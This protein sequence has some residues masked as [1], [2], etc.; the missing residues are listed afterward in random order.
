MAKTSVINLSEKMTPEPNLIGYPILWLVLLA[1]LI[2]APTFKYGLTELDDTIFIRDFHDY[3]EHFSNLFSSFHRGLFDALK[4]PYYR[5]VF[6]DS[7]ILNYWLGNHGQNIFSYHFFNAWFHAAAVVFFYKLL[8]RL[9]FKTVMAFTL[10]AFFAVAPVLTQA[11]AWIPGRND[12]ILALFVLLFINYSIDF[13]RTNQKKFLIYAALNL[14][15]ALFTKETAV[16]APIVLLV[17]LSTFAG[18]RLVDRKTITT[19]LVCILCIVVWYLARNSATVQNGDLITGALPQLWHRLPL[20]LQYFGKIILPFNLSVFPMQDETTYIYGIVSV[21]ILF[22]LIYFSPAKNYKR[23]LGG[24]IIFIVFLVP[25]LIVPS[26]LNQ[27]TFE[28]RLYLP[29]IGFLLILPETIL[30]NGKYTEGQV[31]IYSIVV[32]CL[33]GG[34]TLS[35]QTNFS[36]PYAFWTQAVETSSK[37]AF[38]NMHLSEYEDNL[39]KKC[40]LI[41]HAFQLNPREK[42][43]NFFYAEMLINTGKRDSILSAEPYLQTEKGISNFNKCNFYLARIAIERGDYNSGIEDLTEFLKNEPPQSKEAA[44]ANNNLLLLFINTS[45]TNK[46]I[47]Q[48]RHM[49]DLGIPVPAEV[50]KQYHI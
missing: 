26:S 35:H 49:K 46:I 36:D 34:K 47:S 44:E 13:V 39:D 2:Y 3:N 21:V 7:M 11:V 50:Q 28:H 4:D 5:P 25:A 8:I 19:V 27:Q 22:I 16:F 14:L 12:T 18:V 43:I 33:Y 17:I 32:I 48:A 41:R 23:I 29:M 30:F 10:A 45:Q 6:M 20:L 24:A 37:S 42:Y 1:V 40:A 9:E 15:L 38:A 31:L